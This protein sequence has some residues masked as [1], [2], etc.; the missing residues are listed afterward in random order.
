M[1]TA[2]ITV[3][4]LGLV[5]IAISYM[6]S[7]KMSGIAATEERRE[8]ETVEEYEKR[9][10]LEENFSKRLEAM[11]QEAIEQVDAKLCKLSNEKIMAVNEYSEM[12]LEKIDKN[13]S[14]VVFLYSMLTD[15]EK[16][17]KEFVLGK[18]QEVEP[19]EKVKQVE[20]SVSTLNS[21][22]MILENKVPKQEA[23]QE[24]SE[25]HRAILAMLAE[26]NS[27][28]EVSKQL[29]IGQGEVQLVANLYGGGQK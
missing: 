23:E 14:E 25:M 20:E 21:Q 18:H 10:E 4:V 16:E 26:G 15:K 11:Q 19:T 24:I 27:V 8:L 3:I 17:L 13:Q 12:V 7:E 2:E 9:K 5:I 6:I 22:A 1:S 28:L 29:N